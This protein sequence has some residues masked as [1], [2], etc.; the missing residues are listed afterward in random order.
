MSLKSRAL[1]NELRDWA[2]VVKEVTFSPLGAA[3]YG[4][5]GCSVAWP[6]GALVAIWL[7][8]VFVKGDE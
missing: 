2:A 5:I 7:I 8:T 3:L 6:I 1:K 4:L